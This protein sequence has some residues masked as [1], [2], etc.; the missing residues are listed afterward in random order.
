M[1]EA[2]YRHVSARRIDSHR[3]QHDG[4]DAV[5]PG[6]GG[7]LWL[8]AVSVSICRNGGF[9]LSRQRL[10]RELLHWR[11][12]RTFGARWSNARDHH[13]TRRRL[14]AG[15]KGTVDNFR[16]YPVCSRIFWNGNGQL[17]AWSWSA[18]GICSWQIVCRSPA[19]ELTGKTAGAGPWL[20]GGH[21]CPSLFRDDAFALF[22][23][24]AVVP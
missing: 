20:A 24:A 9:W 22:R 19:D 11:E 6:L 18:I 17:C 8:R 5:W 13:K 14:H 15:S 21:C 1:V 4:P 3:V 10:V 7:A 12:R 16:S 23:P 2:G